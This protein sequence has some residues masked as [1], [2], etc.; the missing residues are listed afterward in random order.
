MMRKWAGTLAQ[1]TA[2]RVAERLCQVMD[3]EPIRIGSGEELR[4]TVSI[5]VAVAGTAG[6]GSFGV[7]GLVEQ[8]DI[9][10]LESKSAGPNQVTF[11]LSA[12]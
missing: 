4:V 5:G 10:L 2:R 12:A 1:A 8:A 11:L 3:D 7:E 9:E 6:E